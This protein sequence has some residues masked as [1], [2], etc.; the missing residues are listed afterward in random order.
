MKEQNTAQAEEERKNQSVRNSPADTEVRGEGGRGGAPGSGAELPLQLLE[1]GHGDADCSPAAH[2]E[3][4]AGADIH[5]AACGG[6]HTRA[7]GCALKEAAA[8]GEPALEQVCPERLEQ[9][10]SVRGK[11]QQLLLPDH[12]PCFLSP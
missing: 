4:H 1:G 7:G 8:H 5:T 9:G 3:D 11:E 12:N 10:K 6:H 2:G